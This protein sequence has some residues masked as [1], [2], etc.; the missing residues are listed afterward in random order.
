MNIDA[1]D[2][3]FE[4]W[5]AIESR[6]LSAP[7]EA[8]YPVVGKCAQVTE[9]GAASPPRQRRHD[10]PGITADPLAAN[11]IERALVEMEYGKWLRCGHWG[12]ADARW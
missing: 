4:L 8:I 10:I 7:V 5:K 12:D 1:L 3:G 11:S 2:R 6:F 9:A